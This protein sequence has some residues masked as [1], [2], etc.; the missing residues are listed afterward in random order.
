VDRQ[1]PTDTQSQSHT[2]TD[3]WDRG[4]VSKNSAYARYIDREWRTKKWR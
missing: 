1:R 3:R 2:Q 4:Q